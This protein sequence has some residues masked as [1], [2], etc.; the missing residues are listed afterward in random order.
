VAD[1]QGETA[2]KLLVEYLGAISTVV[3]TEV[4]GLELQVHQKQA[5][6][7]NVERNKSKK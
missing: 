4:S 7:M 3:V 1:L 6:V 5:Q 2:Q